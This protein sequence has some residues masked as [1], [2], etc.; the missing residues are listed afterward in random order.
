MMEHPHPLEILIFIYPR[1]EEG[2]TAT[3]LSLFQKRWY[4]HTVLS[5]LGA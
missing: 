2:Y 4:P 3:L 5:P 1:H